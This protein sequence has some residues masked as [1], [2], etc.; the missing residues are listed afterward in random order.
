M[1]DKE[2]IMLVLLNSV[3][4]ESMIETV[5]SCLMDEKEA[6]IKFDVSV[7]TVDTWYKMGK[8][9]GYK[10]GETVLF[11]KNEKDPRNTD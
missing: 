3:G 4:K 10:V 6:S 5:L 1:N 11:L 7:P 2:V 9:K 8:I